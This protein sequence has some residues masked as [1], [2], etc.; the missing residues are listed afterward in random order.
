MFDF[1]LEESKRQDNNVAVETIQTSSSEEIAKASTP[2]KPPKR[3]ILIT[4]HSLVK[5]K[6]YCGWRGRIQAGE[7]KKNW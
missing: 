5:R 7:E 2:I 4:H 6:R 1:L 3:S